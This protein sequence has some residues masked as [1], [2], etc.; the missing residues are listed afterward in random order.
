MSYD[1]LKRKIQITPN[2]VIV[3][4]SWSFY[5]N[6]TKKWMSTFSK[7]VEMSVICTTGKIFYRPQRSSNDILSFG[8]N[9]G[10]AFV[11]YKR[12][13]LT[14]RSMLGHLPWLHLQHQLHLSPY[15]LRTSSVLYR[16]FICLL[17]LF[18]MRTKSPFLYFFLF[19]LKYREQWLLY[20]KQKQNYNM[21]MW[22]SLG[23]YYWY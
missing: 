11:H 21:K 1:G 6:L 19:Y 7:S 15:E 16:L 18:F 12:I 23:V 3:I 13:S 9:G 10:W 14:V 2:Y 8:V 17:F 4:A 20:L 5:C 22:I